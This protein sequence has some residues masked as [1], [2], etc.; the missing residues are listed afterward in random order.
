MCTLYSTIVPEDVR[1][2]QLK[3]LFYFQYYNFM[4]QMRNIFVFILAVQAGEY[5]EILI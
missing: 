5:I 4:L 3:I 2:C 1:N